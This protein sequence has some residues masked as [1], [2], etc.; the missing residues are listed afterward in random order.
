[1]YLL[2]KAMLSTPKPLLQ[3]ATPSNK[4]ELES[5]W[6]RIPIQGP[7]LFPAC[8]WIQIWHLTS[9]L[10]KWSTFNQSS[11]SCDLET[12]F[13]YISHIMWYIFKCSEVNIK[14]TGPARHLVLVW[15]PWL[16]KKVSH[17]RRND[18]F[19]KINDWHMTPNVYN[20]I[21]LV[22]IANTDSVWMNHTDSVCKSNTCPIHTGEGSGT[23]SVILSQYV[24]GGAFL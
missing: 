10:I 3:V 2:L 9:L 13:E 15:T 20:M 22:K 12:A 19:K 4:L 6:T 23:M 16:S 24:A 8:I 14:K 7:S 17:C 1:M 11:S 18:W 21:N 5:L